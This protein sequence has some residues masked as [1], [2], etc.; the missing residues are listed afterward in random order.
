MIASSH[1]LAVA[2]L[3]LA[4]VWPVAACTGG[5]SPGAAAKPTGTSTA[6]S[7]VATRWWSN[8]AATAGSTIDPKNPGAV[9]AKLHAS[10]SAYCGMLK[11][12]LAAGK[13]I[14][15]G[16]SATDPAVLSSAEAFVDELQQ[17]APASVSGQWQVLGKAIVAFVKSS[18]K[19]LGANGPNS[20]TISTAVAKISAD[21]TA[22]CHVNLAA[23]APK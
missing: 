4:L 16:A 21:A 2:A 6:S 11:Q 7:L 20:A 17:V 15:P 1:R 10:Q 9:A 22:N 5:S 12:T 23:A 13:S 8:D 14:L 3:T 19:S 18:G